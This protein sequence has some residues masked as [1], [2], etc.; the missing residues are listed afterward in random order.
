[1]VEFNPAGLGLYKSSRQLRIQ[2]NNLTMLCYLKLEII[3]SV[4][5]TQRKF[6]NGLLFA[7]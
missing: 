3:Q 1:M 5:L 7:F 4:K 6:D 2:L